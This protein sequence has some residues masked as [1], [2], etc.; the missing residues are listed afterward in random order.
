MARINPEITIFLSLT[1]EF[2]RRMVIKLLRRHKSTGIPYLVPG[3]AWL[4]V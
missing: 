4:G 3:T 2:E 1:D